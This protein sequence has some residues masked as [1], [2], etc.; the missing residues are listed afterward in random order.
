ML[1]DR[2]SIK[3]EDFTATDLKIYNFIN[4]ESNSKHFMKSMT[5]ISKVIGVSNAAITRFC[6]KVQY[7]GW[8]ELQGKLKYEL[9]ERTSKYDGVSR[10]VHQMIY[11]LSRT[12]KAINKDA[13]KM[14]AKKIL[15]SDFIF[16]YG[17]AFTKIQAQ[18]FR[19]KL[20]KININ[21]QDFEVAGETGFILPKNNSVHI[22]ISMSGMNPNVKRAVNKLTTVQMHNQSIYTIG[23]TPNSN[24]IDL[25]NEHIGG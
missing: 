13:I 12:D 23:S 8:K 18:A 9:K 7:S 4:K 14:V 21:A 25:I 2:M 16:I 1:K 19:L 20:N 24:V 11:S 10:E 5:Q 22:F 17:E 15:E 6:Q 3:K